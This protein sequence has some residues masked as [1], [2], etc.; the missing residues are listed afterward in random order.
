MAR[1]TFRSQNVQNTPVS[2]HFWR[3]R[4]RKIARPCGAIF[5]SQNVKTTRGSDHFW[6]FRCRFA[7]LHYR[8]LHYTTLQYQFT[9]HYA[10]VHSTTLNDTTPHYITL[11]DIAT[12]KRGPKLRCFVHFDFN[13]CFTPQRRALFRHLNFQM[14]SGPGVICTF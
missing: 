9:L 3:L 7:S 1:S 14:W 10:P 8:T 11:N 4:C 12:S 6:R 2:E 13:M 5:Q